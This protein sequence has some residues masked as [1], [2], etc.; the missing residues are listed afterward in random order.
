MAGKDPH[1]GLRR[2]A[3]QLYQKL[4]MLQPLCQQAR[5]ELLLESRRHAATI[6]LRQIPCV[7][8][9]RAALLNKPCVILITDD[10]FRISLSCRVRT[11]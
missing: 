11:E 5:R 7:G 3:E 6:R 9:I 8:P 4:D 10:P 1:P 2:R